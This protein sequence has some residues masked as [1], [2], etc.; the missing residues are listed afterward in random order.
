MIC[1]QQHRSS[2]SKSKTS[3]LA[4]LL[5]AALFAPIALTAQPRG[6]G[7]HG[8]HE[9]EFAAVTQWMR[10]EGFVPTDKEP[11]L[12]AKADPAYLKYD[13]QWYEGSLAGSPRFY[14][15]VYFDARGRFDAF[16]A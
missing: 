6:A 1:P 5:T 14:V 15:Y 13:Y 12:I 3:V 8:K 11:A 7:N 16:T 9:Q 4:A 10:L 2:L